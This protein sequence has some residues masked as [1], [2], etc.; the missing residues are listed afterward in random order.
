MTSLFPQLLG[1][2]TALGIGLLVGLERE[3]VKGTGP[4]RAAAGVRTFILL[5]L[6]G[7]V[8]HLIGTVGV[9]IGGLFVALAMLASYRRTQAADPGL[10]TEVAM[11]LAFFLGVLAMRATPV[12]AAL[13]TVLAIVLASKSTLHRFT[14]Q[15]LT[16]QE[17]ND[18]L[19]LAAAAF[20]VLPLLPDRWVDP[21]NA[22]NPRKL[23]LLVVAIM[24]VGSAGYVALRMFGSRLGLTLAGLAGGFVSSTATIAAMAERARLSPGSN[25]SFASAAL[26]SN[27]ATFAQLSLVLAALSP[28]LLRHAAWPLVAAGLAAVV[29]ALLAFG[30]TPATV[31]D[32]RTLAG[33]RPFE[34]LRT[35]GFVALVAVILVATAIARRWLG[36]DQLPWVLAGA[37]L[38]D[39]HAAAASAAQLVAKGEVAATQAML[40]LLAAVASNSLLKCVVA[41]LRGGRH[42]ALRVIP[43]IV[44]MVV[45][46]AGALWV[47]A[48]PT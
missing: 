16:E 7:A 13:G 1:L 22:I 47:R 40:G 3:R 32:F 24:A 2:L 39:V 19:L 4:E 43:G 25:G 30:R 42:F 26:A 15:I 34:P 11:L 44:I 5:S 36:D 37:G 12:A 45:A 31:T 18:L 9:A 46:F 21:W 14:K 41:S 35:L 17:L 38:A 8:A 6:T 20:V 48:A 27:V 23:W 10:T 33:E 28:E 29:S